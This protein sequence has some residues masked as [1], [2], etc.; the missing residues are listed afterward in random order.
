MALALPN[1]EYYW[2]PPLRC[3]RTGV[4]AVSLV[5]LA[6]LTVLTLPPTAVA[7][8]EKPLN[9]PFPQDVID[10]IRCDVCNIMTRKAYDLVHA[11]FV[12]SDST[13]V[14]V[15]E[16]DVMVA[17]EDVCN[18]FAESGQWIR[19]FSIG[20]TPSALTA[21]PAPLHLTLVPLPNHTKCKRTCKTI[22]E[23]CEAVIDHDSMDVLSPQLLRLRKY[24]NAD[25]FARSVCDVASF[26]TERG[27]IPPQRYEVLGG[28][29]AE[30]VPEEIEQKEMDIE[31][32]MD[33]MERKN[34]QRHEIYSREEVT[35]MQ[36]SLARGDRESASRVD[37]S[38]NRLTDEEF[39]ELHHMI[40]DGRMS[41]REHGAKKA[42]AAGHAG[43]GADGVEGD[44]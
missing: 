43:A 37:S 32:M 25:A 7:R 38:I 29:I 26:C 4:K 13:R 16:E 20:K 23:A 33:F 6:A 14:P 22:W 34:N 21:A 1:G 17:I 9:I 42:H 12:L 30:D 18:P 15:N 3:K 24:A 41:H 44:L 39:E 2:A 8:K 35:S 31:R 11:L 27:A 28:M 5:V 36:E 40:K 19:L 10:N